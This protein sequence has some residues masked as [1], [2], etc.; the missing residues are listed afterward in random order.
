MTNKE[1][2]QE[3]ENQLMDYSCTG[4]WDDGFVDYDR[5]AIIRILK[6]QREELIKLIENEESV[7]TK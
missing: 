7:K 2:L 6:A 4:E 5:S 3:T 1:M